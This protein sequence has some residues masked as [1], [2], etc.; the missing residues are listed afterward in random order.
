VLTGIVVGIPVCAVR[1]PIHE[2][3]YGISQTAGEKARPRKT[4]PYAL[5]YAPFA[6]VSGL[7]EA[8]FYALNNSLIN[9][10]KPF[11]KEQFSLTDREEPLNVDPIKG[12]LER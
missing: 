10:D 8:P 3:K 12:T 4:I 5:I 7:I 9:Y 6:V 2:E 1:Q 11:S